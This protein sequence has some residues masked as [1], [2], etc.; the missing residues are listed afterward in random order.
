ME[1]PFIGALQRQWP[2][3]KLALHTTDITKTATREEMAQAT[4]KEI[5]DVLSKEGMPE[6]YQEIVY[7]GQD[8]ILW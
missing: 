8:L 4:T 5:Q 3:H 2:D 6:R 1:L 7:T